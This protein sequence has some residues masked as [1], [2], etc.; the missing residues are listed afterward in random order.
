[1]GNNPKYIDALLSLCVEQ[2]VDIILPITDA[3][4]LPLAKKADDFKKKGIIVPISSYGSY[5]TATDKLFLFQF[6]EKND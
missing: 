3:E 2:K 4:L 1:M 6:L 5:Q